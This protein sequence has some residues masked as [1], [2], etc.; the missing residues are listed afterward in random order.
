MSNV[1]L[2]LQSTSTPERF[3]GTKEVAAFIGKPASWVHNCAARHGIPRYRIGNHW[4]FRLSEVA[5][6]V[7]GRRA[8]S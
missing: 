3:V 7:E 5:A 2:E 6:W 1:V 4:R 8:A